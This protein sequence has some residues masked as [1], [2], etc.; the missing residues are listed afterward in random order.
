MLCIRV[1][2]VYST[3]ASQDH[4]NTE[5]KLA[6][7]NSAVSKTLQG[8]LQPIKSFARCLECLGLKILVPALVVMGDYDIPFNCL[9][10]CGL[11]LPFLIRHFPSS[12][13]WMSVLERPEGITSFLVYLCTLL[14]CAEPRTV[15]KE[16]PD[17]DEVDH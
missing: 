15:L 5:Q 9:R 12:Q 10:H 17:S 8:Q 16:G 11:V 1:K 6:I 2:N 7:K 14:I 3:T 13:I 4:S